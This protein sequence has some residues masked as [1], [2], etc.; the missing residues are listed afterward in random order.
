MT[1]EY[2]FLVVYLGFCV[3]RV[4]YLGGDVREYGDLLKVHTGSWTD[5]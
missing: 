5:W 1:W 2:L 4:Q 3:V